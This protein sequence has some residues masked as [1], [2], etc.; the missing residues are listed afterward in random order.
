MAVGKVSD[1]LVFARCS[2]CQDGFAVRKSD[3]QEHTHDG[4]WLCSV[5]RSIPAETRAAIDEAGG[6]IPPQSERG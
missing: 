5:C 3:V 4:N 6:E 2:W 1:P